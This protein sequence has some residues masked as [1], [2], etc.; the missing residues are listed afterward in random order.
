VKRD[1]AVERIMLRKAESWWRRY[2]VGDERPPITGSDLS[3]AWLKHTYPKHRANT[4][5][6]ADD[7]EAALLTEYGQIRRCYRRYEADKKLWENRIKE[8]LG[9]REGLRWPGGKL[10][11]KKT[12]DSHVVEWEP[13]AEALLARHP[14][15][16]R[17][18]EDFTVTKPGHRRI[19]FKPVDGEEEELG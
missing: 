18:R 3:S 6:I 7:E 19:H 10:T 16:D 1:A 8:A 12:R 9:E 14:E 2:L 17:L 5:D 15:G 13:L 4:L 11:W